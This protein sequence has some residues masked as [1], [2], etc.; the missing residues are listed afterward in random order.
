ML[1]IDGRIG[2]TSAG[3]HVTGAGVA[4]TIQKVRDAVIAG[5]TVVV[6]NIVV[7]LAIDGVQPGASQKGVIAIAAANRIVAGSA[8]D[9]IV[10]VAAN[11]KVIRSIA[12]QRDK[13]G[14]AASFCSSVS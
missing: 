5:C 8:V 2:A 6:Q 7:G 3:E 13:N 4:S 14:D 12:H 9:A 10:P 11:Q 1:K